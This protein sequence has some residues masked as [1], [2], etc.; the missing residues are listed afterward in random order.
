MSANTSRSLSN[1]GKLGT[2][3][4]RDSSMAAIV[5]SQIVIPPGSTMTAYETALY[6]TAEQRKRQQVAVGSRSEAEH[7]GLTVILLAI[8]MVA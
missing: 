4:Q 8:M 6:E 7:F 5:T 1:V 3:L 2:W